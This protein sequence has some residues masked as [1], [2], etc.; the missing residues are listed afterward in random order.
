M[1]S[2]FKHNL[3]AA[4]GV[5]V[6]LGG[7]CS[8]VL[9]L[10]A[11]ES[12]RQARAVGDPRQRSIDVQEPQRQSPA[13]GDPAIAR[14]LID[15]LRSTDYQERM[16]ASRRLTELGK[17][18]IPLLFEAIRS[19]DLETSFRAI[20]IVQRIGL[21]SDLDTLEQI[22]RESRQLPAAFRDQFEEW[23]YQ[24]VSRWKS[25]QSQVAI[26]KLE[27]KGVTVVETNDAANLGLMLIE[28]LRELDQLEERGSEVKQQAEDGV[29][30]VL[31]EI[32]NLKKELAGE[33][34]AE[35]VLPNLTPQRGGEREFR[36]RRIVLG[37]GRVIVP[38][39]LDPEVSVRNVV[40]GAG[41]QGDPRDLNQL[42]FVAN[43]NEVEFVE[44]EITPEIL[45]EL[46]KVTRLNS[47]L[48]TRCSF[49]YADVQKFKLERDEQA[50]L[51]LMAVGA[52][53]LGVYGPNPG[54]PD[55]GEGSYVSLVSPDSAASEAGLERG[56]LIIR[57]DSDPIRS[58]AELS[59]VI[60][61]KPVGE[62]IKIAVRRNREEKVLTAKL[63][64]R[65]GI[66]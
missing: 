38:D 39:S 41:W 12:P 26:G 55:S 48:L 64:S 18:T 6:V 14:Q 8:M 45:D 27:A 21:N 40:L 3:F 7:F 59:L 36:G 53:Y 54:D 25:N 50:P 65:D 43:L 33:S 35:R 52:G 57:V 51:R 13:D 34:V 42:R 47:L 24:A 10:A 9:P 11:Q 1:K 37:G 19:T 62:E 17:A 28:D 16:A 44:Q 66:R 46:R 29:D 22:I 2:N 49:S 15:Q 20:H 5:A 30:S 63:K 60:S 32:G 56:D 61:S 58:F 31:R 4:V 23:S